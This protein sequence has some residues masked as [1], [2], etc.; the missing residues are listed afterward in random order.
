V[1]QGFLN[2]AN[3]IYFVLN[4]KQRKAEKE[5]NA[6]LLDGKRCKWIN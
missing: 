6:T 2:C 3:K 1:Q 5:K 4:E